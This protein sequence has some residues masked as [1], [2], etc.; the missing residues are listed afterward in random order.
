MKN[1]IRIISLVLVFVMLAS[2]MTSCFLFGGDKT[3]DG[4]NNSGNDDN[5]GG[6][7][8]PDDGNETPDGGNENPDGG[9]E[10]PDDGGNEDPDN[11]G[12]S[13]AQDYT[14]IFTGKQSVLLIGQ[15]NMA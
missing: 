15:S 13:G 12:N 8:T 1:V 6:N 11:G 9:N 10:T 3:P 2:A 14:T 5:N 4:G 7:E